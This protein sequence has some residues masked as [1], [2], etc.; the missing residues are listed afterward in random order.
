M[1]LATLYASTALAQSLEPRRWTHLPVDANFIGVAAGYSRGDILF[2][3]ALQI[4]DAGVD[5]NFSGISYIR[6]HAFF[7][8][9]ARIEVTLP[10]AIG[11]W[12]GLL[13][14]QPA[15]VRR[16]GFPDPSVRWSINLLGSPAL[17]GREFAA[18]R[19]A[20]PV[21]T[22]LGVAVDVTLPLGEY[23]ADRL[24]NLGGNR[25]VLRPQIGI[26]HSR[27]QW[28][29]EATGSV[30]LFGDNDE[31]FSGT[32]RQQDPLWFVQGHVIYSFRPGVWA[33]LSS[34]YGYGG[35]NTISG[36]DKDDDGRVSF[37]AA[38]F[39]LP[40]GPRQN[41]K[42]SYARSQTNTRVGSDLDTLLA[43]WSM[44]F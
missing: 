10:Y 2:D 34:G 17:K 3:P 19:A 38:S 27:H 4:E 21:R 28:E 5:L 37:W 11:H 43:A 1:L 40:L 6:S 25:Y 15:S 16:H 41:I 39:G 20:N 36:V 30:F 33:G 44:A 26:L 22:V 18:Y 7:G 42:F 31:F 8:R 24:I 12:E 14:Q 23:R 29:F 35:D 13:N 32:V 9:T